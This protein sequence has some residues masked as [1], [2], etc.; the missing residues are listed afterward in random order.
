MRS[1]VGTTKQRLLIALCFFQH[2]FAESSTLEIA[3]YSATYRAKYNG[4]DI[5][6]M[7]KLESIQDRYHESSEAKSVLGKISE[8]S[9]FRLSNKGKLKSEY[10]SYQ[11]SLMGVT[12][13]E[14]QN[15]DW[16]NN[17]VEYKKNG[18]LTT[19][20][21]KNHALDMVTHKLQIRRDL[22]AG[23]KIFSY[24][25]MSRGQIKE[26]VYEA[27]GNEVLKTS[28]GP[29]KTTKVRRVVNSNKKRDTVIWMADDWEFLIV[30][31][32]HSEKG[33]RHQLDITK[34]Q[35]GGKTIVPFANILETSL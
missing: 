20:P 2:V 3:E 5:T 30:K 19:T 12:R 21:L 4:L 10:Y 27:F 17:K 7:H 28:L 13:T 11:R 31:L 18:K 25:V 35:V 29:L 15:F 26:Y 1:K 9:Q 32:V 34:G 22:K 14:T 23:L 24:L 33:E 8:S 16:L 6:A